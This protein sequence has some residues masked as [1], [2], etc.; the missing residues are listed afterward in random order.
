MSDEIKRPRLL[1]LHQGSRRGEHI[2]E[3]CKAQEP[4][5]AAF[6][7]KR[8]DVEVLK[9]NVRKS[10]QVYVAEHSVRGTPA[11]ALH[12]VDV[13]KPVIADRAFDTLEELE[14]WVDLALG[15]K[16]MSTP[17]A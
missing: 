16:P 11:F 13:A 3:A 4:I 10:G 14:A 7:A 9:S 8:L 6:A 1:F 2:C 17:A 12:L 5:V 15:A